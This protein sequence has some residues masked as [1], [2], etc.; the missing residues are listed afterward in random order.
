M[1]FWEKAWPIL[2]VFGVLI[3]I[4]VGIFGYRIL[5]QQKEEEE[6]AKKQDV[7]VDYIV[8]HWKKP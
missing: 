7:S 5:Q 6:E 2:L 8:E 4:W 1:T 3:L